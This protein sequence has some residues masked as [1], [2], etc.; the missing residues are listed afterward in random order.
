MNGIRF[1]DAFA[2][3]MHR[4]SSLHS[5]A[6]TSFIS[7]KLNINL[8]VSSVLVP[9]SLSSL[10]LSLSIYISFSPP[11]SFLLP[12]AYYSHSS[13]PLRFLTDDDDIND[14]ARLAR[15]KIFCF[16]LGGAQGAIPS[17]VDA[18]QGSLIASPSFTVRDHHDRSRDI[19][20]LTAS[21]KVSDILWK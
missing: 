16:S 18:L 4:P 11:I 20:A 14:Q 5:F 1:Q 17:L 19:A 12:L 8:H 10:F 15:V 2:V 9:S 6:F 21:I 7:F 13:S 3:F